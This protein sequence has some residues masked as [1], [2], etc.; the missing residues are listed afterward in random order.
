M[1]RAAT[2][3]ILDDVCQNSLDLLFA[4]WTI[5]Q[6]PSLSVARFGDSHVQFLEE[7]HSASK[8]LG[9]ENMT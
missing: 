1:L 4:V 3:F 9:G 6:T 2:G 7:L 8:G 5:E